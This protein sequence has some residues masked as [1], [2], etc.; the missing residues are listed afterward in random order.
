MIECT[1]TCQRCGHNIVLSD[2]YG[3]WVARCPDCL[4]D[5]GGSEHELLQGHGSTPEDA[6]Q[7]WFDNR[8]ALGIE[9]EIRLTALG[10]AATEL[11]HFVV[12]EAPEGWVISFD[13]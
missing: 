6:L 2:V 11:R 9:P 12:P 7:N 3:E 1:V 5:G 8:E 10:W 13:S 4:D